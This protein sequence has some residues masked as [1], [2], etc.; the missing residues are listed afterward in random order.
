M[1]VIFVVL[2]GDR[3]KG[4]AKR[5]LLADKEVSCV[6]TWKCNVIFSFNID[7][8]VCI[9]SGNEVHIHYILMRLL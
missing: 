4:N 8:S 6:F 5:T 7:T 2:T 9:C 3:S 1:N